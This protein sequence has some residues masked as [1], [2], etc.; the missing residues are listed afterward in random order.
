MVISGLQYIGV[1]VFITL[2]QCLFVYRLSVALFY[3]K[4]KNK[5]KKPSSKRAQ[6]PG[7][8][9]LYSGA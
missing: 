6:I 7:E 9:I 2:F 8:W 1:L 4:V 3:V 5:K